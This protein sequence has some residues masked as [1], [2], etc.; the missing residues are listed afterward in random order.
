MPES[1]GVLFFS[2][3]QPSRFCTAALQP[4]GASAAPC[5]H[6]MRLG[7][8]CTASH[9]TQ[10]CDLQGSSRASQ[11]SSCLCLTADAKDRQEYQD[12]FP[13]R[14]SYRRACSTPHGRASGKAAPLDRGMH[15]LMHASSLST[16]LTARH[17]VCCRVVGDQS[18]AG[19]HVNTRSKTHTRPPCSLGLCVRWH[20]LHS[21]RRTIP[22]PYVLPSE[23]EVM[24][25][26]R[27]DPGVA[28]LIIY[29]REGLPCFQPFGSVALRSAKDDA[30]Q[31][32]QET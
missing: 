9:A 20:Q 21:M 14:C 32:L 28:L 16:P 29:A 31:K 23:D 25:P 12:V 6:G 4:A 19:C 5:Y 27:F 15:A 8:L 11:S 26:H 7:F 18:D 1:K 10:E 22:D 24:V 3:L 13:V 17:R 30:Q 2:P